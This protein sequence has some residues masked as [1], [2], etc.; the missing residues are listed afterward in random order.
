MN[1]FE[2]KSDKNNKRLSQMWTIGMGLMIFQQLCGGNA[3]M[4]HMEE[5]INKLILTDQWDGTVQTLTLGIYL[6]QVSN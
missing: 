3:L 2:Y 1:I 5:I 4:F 6:S